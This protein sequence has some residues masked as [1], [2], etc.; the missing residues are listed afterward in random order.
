MDIRKI[1]VIGSFAAGA[2][3][4]LAPLASADE[5]TNLV[6]S[7][8]ASQNSQFVGQADFAG[9]PSADVSTSTTPGV[10]DTVLPA[11]APNTTD[12]GQL[13][14]LDYEL[15]GV[16][17]V[18]AG[19]VSDPG[20]YNVFN[21]AETKF[22]DAY[23]VALYAFE[24]NGALIP[25][26]DLFGNHIYDALA[27]LAVATGAFDYFFNFGV[28]DLEGY[29]GIFPAAAAGAAAAPTE[30][31]STVASEVA[32]A[33]SQFQ[34]E[35]ALA[36]VPSTDYA[37]GAQGFDFINA[38]DITKDAPASGTPSILD[39]E[40]FGVKPFEAGVAGDPGAFNLF[41]GAEVRFDD[42]FNVAEYALLNGG[43]VDPNMGDFFGS[44][45]AGF[46]GDTAAQAFD[47]FY[48]EAIGDLSGFFQVPL[49]FLD[50]VP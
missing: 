48:N 1:A 47:A 27:D 22:D 13:T 11:D 6:D 41:N 14:I 28:G 23:N 12:P 25:A 43:A 35:A 18:K 36:G 2:A 38:A 5:F 34:F 44:L 40:L 49:T 16:D 33:N 3:L 30:I 46:A 42:A 9:V 20:S 31:T 37:V 8:I 32:L 45:P 26:A 10:F 7:E 50:I 15:F 21:G 19:T 24:H 17:P 4:A 39:Y 29:Y